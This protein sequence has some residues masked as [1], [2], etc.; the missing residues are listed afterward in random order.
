MKV[1]VESKVRTPKQERSIKK[2]ENIRTTSLALFCK[3]GYHSVT[4]NQIAK[5]AHMSVGSLYEY[6]ANKE[7][8]LVE[9]L[10]DYFE[11]FLNHQD[12]ISSFFKNDIHLLNKRIWLHN[13][14]NTL[15]ASHKSSL[16][17]NR[18]L[19]YLYFS[20]PEVAQICNKQKSQM[21]SIIYNSLLELKDELIVA[22][23][24][25]ATVV[26]MDM[27]DKLIDRVTLYP[28]EIDHERIINESIDAI[29]LYLFGKTF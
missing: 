28:L 3:H 1:T 6:Y 24:E 14:I 23:L 15:V 7:A 19:Q 12:E 22:D 20:I 16:D 17:F 27:L 2:K 21:R 9:I 26:F 5:E 4:T 8:I 25:A 13:L 29:C 10:D 11:S 18:E